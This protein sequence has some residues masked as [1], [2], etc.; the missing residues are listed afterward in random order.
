MTA[1][2]LN[3]ALIWGPRKILQWIGLDIKRYSPAQTD[4]RAFPGRPSDLYKDVSEL[5]DSAT[6]PIIFDVGANEGQTIRLIKRHF[7]DAI[8]HAFEPSPA[9]FR[10]LADN[11]SGAPGI[12]LNNVGVGSTT[13]RL[14]LIENVYSD[15]SSFLE[16]GDAWGRIARRT[17]VPVTTI[18]E[19]CKEHNISWIDLLKIDTQGYDYKVLSG[20]THMLGDNKIGLVLAEIVF[21]R[22]YEGIDRFDTLLS[23]M[24]DKN[25]KL[26]GF[27]DQ[28]K[29]NGILSWSDVLFAHARHSGPHRSLPV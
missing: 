27:Y 28:N 9:T 17:N 25:Y 10:R 3:R 19:Y 6:K 21:D 11:V 22:M 12:T 7:S 23:F 24:L 1:S 4:Q 18:D 14:D 16:P 15:M 13:G 20:S 8:V 26:V 29:R 2:R 5:L